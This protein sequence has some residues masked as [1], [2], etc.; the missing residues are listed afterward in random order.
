MRPRRELPALSLLHMHMS[1]AVAVESVSSGEGAALFYA[2]KLI[3]SST[4]VLALREISGL[5]GNRSANISQML[6]GRDS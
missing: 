2:V 3:S 6:V 5:R 4:L 1:A